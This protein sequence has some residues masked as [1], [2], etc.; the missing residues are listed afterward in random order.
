MHF[1]VEPKYDNE[2]LHFVRSWKFLIYYLYSTAT[3]RRLSIKKKHGWW[4]PIQ[5]CTMLILSPSLFSHSHETEPCSIGF[6][7]CMAWYCMSLPGRV[8]IWGQNEAH[9]EEM[10]SRGSH[11]VL[12]FPLKCIHGL[13][14]YYMGLLYYCMEFLNM[15]MNFET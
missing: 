1:Y 5:V 10:I 6:S 15:H 2:T 11:T 3:Q 8:E 14:R 4:H 7:F 13:N 12:S 9:K